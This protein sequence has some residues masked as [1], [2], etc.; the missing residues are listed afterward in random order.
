MLLG[1]KIKVVLGFWHWPRRVLV[2]DVTCRRKPR[3]AARS[4]TFG[5]L[6]VRGVGTLDGSN[7]PRV[8]ITQGVGWW[9]RFTGW[10]R[11][12][13]YER[14][15]DAPAVQSGQMAKAGQILAMAVSS[16]CLLLKSSSS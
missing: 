13:G 5:W 2:L 11:A 14:G 4:S 8:K 6:Q 15:S 3:A 10:T 12:Y 9:A 7:H 1:A 16:A